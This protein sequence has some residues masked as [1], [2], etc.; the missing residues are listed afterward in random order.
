LITLI[1]TQGVGRRPVGNSQY[2][3]FAWLIGLIAMPTAAYTT[4]SSFLRA[5]ERPDR[6]LSAHLCAAAVTCVGIVGIGAW[7]LL[8][9]I[10]GL[11]ASAV[12]AMFVMFGGS[13]GPVSCRHRAMPRR[14]VL[15]E[16]TGQ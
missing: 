13:S 6:E 4:F 10:I 3:G 12:T 11:L 9:A 15:P 16:S 5:Y 14:R 7:G 8:G 2:D 1:F